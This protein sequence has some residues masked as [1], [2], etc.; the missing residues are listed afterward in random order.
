[1]GVTSWEMFHLSLSLT[2]SIMSALTCTVHVDMCMTLNDGT[3]FMSC[4]YQHVL[5]KEQHAHPWYPWCLQHM[6][7]IINPKGW[8]LTIMSCAII[9]INIQDT[10]DDGHMILSDVPSLNHVASSC[11]NMLMLGWCYNIM[12]SLLIA[13]GYQH[14]I[15]SCSIIL[16]SAKADQWVTNINPKGWYWTRSCC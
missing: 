14:D 11:A 8:L 10:H 3:S 9:D 2:C 5:S 7:S 15:M 4:T 6:M 13:F 12:M 1:M 16:S